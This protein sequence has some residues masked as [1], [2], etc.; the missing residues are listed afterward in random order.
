MP[1]TFDVNKDYKDEKEDN[2]VDVTEMECRVTGC[3]YGTGGAAYKTSPECTTYAARTADLR[4]HLD[5]DHP[6][7]AQGL[8]GNRPGTSTKMK[9]CETRIE[10][11]TVGTELTLTEWVIFEKKW[12]RYLEATRLEG[13]AA[14]HQLW[15]AMD[16]QTEIDM[17]HKGVGDSRDVN[18]IM[19]NLKLSEI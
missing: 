5:M 11:P 9:K 13:V 6:G 19:E 8:Q 10:R 2:T 3:N 17:I 16:Q 4:L 14:C 7:W 18:E 1:N 12:N 15:A